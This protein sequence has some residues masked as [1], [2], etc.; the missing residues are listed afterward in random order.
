MTDR[1]EAQPV[2]ELAPEPPP[3]G[4]RVWLKENLFST[5]ASAV[6]SVLSILLVLFAYRGLLAF[7]FDP[8]R[9]WDAVTFNMRLLMVQAYP[10]E[11]FTRVWLSVAIVV[12]L[13]VATLAFYRIGGRMS[14]RRL[15][16]ILL[17][18]GGA[19]ALGGVLGPF[20]MTGRVWWIG[21]GLVVGVAGYVT[22]T[23]GGE[24]AKQPII[25]IMG[26]VLA[27]VAGLIILLWTIPVPVPADVDGAQTIVLEQIATSTRIPWTVITV[28]AVIVYFIVAWL[29]GVI[30]ENVGKK[31]IVTLWVFAYPVIIL[32]ILRDPEV[33]YGRIMTWYVPVAIGF[34]VV[35]G[36][37]LNYL[38]S[39]SAGERGRVLGAVILVGAL[40]SFLIPMEFVLRFLLVLLAM[41]ALAAPTFG[42]EG[43]GRRNFLGIWAGA[44]AVTVFLFVI[45]TSP[46]TVVVPGSFFVGGLALTLMLSVSAIVVS[47]PIGVLLALG[48]TSTMPIFRLMSTVYIEIVRGVP[49]ITWLLIA[50][51]MLPVSLPE[52][53]EIG[54]V[55]RAIGAMV[56]FSAAYLA[57]N[58]RG[59]LQ[60]IPKG[61]YEASKAL[62]MT[63]AQM[64]LFITLPQALR[65]V[66]PA[67]VG[68]VIAIFKDTSL[69]TIVGLFDFLHLAR[70]VIPAQ[71]QPFSFLGSIKETLI[72]AAIIYWIFTFT[73]SRISLRLEKKLGVGER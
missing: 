61:Q 6:M 57:E 62:G 58:V 50:F 35:G 68:Q 1:I 31:V 29:R 45:I 8:S 64:T 5:P 70:Q 33:D 17:A 10:V 47:F 23:V 51:L 66:I 73:F 59:G 41:F 60:A 20:S 44:V 56:F 69:V 67:L 19:V 48:R 72:F 9:R 37:I 43:S 55:M 24:R 54:G 49:L 30:P 13:I 42:G 15:G 12:T 14:R 52:G 46:S 7:V 21:I 2:L 32:V 38:A 27:I 40:A 22:R 39:S 16:G 63:T 4:P 36:L 71:S 34:I 3:Q 65:A 26:V 28:L 53:V 18:V 25:P 11:Q